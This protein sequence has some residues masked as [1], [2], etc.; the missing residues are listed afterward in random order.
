MADP[1]F[2]RPASPEA[3]QK[4]ETITPTE[5][6]FLKSGDEMNAENRGPESLGE[7][8]ARLA[9]EGMAKIN[10]MGKNLN[11]QAEAGAQEFKQETKSLWGRVKDRMF[12]KKEAAPIKGEAD[13]LKEIEKA[14]AVYAEFKKK[15]E[16]VM[17]TGDEAALRG[18]ESSLSQAYEQLAPKVA[19]EGA[20]ESKQWKQALKTGEMPQ[21]TEA[22]AKL[23]DVTRR[24]MEVRGKLNGAPA[25]NA[26]AAPSAAPAAPDTREQPPVP[27]A[28]PE[29]ANPLKKDF[30]ECGLAGAEAA[31]LE[32]GRAKLESA[33]ATSPAAEQAPAPKPAPAAEKPAAP[34]EAAPENPDQAERAEYEKMAAG[35]PGEK[36]VGEYLR[37][38]KL[39][40][41][42]YG[43]IVGQSFDSRKGEIRLTYEDGSQF[44]KYATGMMLRILPGGKVE[45][46]KA[47]AVPSPEAAAPGKKQEE[48]Q[49]VD[50]DVSDLGETPV[51][52]VVSGEIEAK[53][54]APEP[55]REPSVVVESEAVPKPQ[56]EIVEEPE[57][58][59]ELFTDAEKARLNQD[60]ERLAQMVKDAKERAAEPPEDDANV[61]DM[62]DIGGGNFVSAAE[63]AAREKAP[64][65]ALPPS[66]EAP[67]PAETPA[68]AV[69]PGPDLEVT[70]AP[71]AEAAPEQAPSGEV[72]EVEMAKAKEHPLAPESLPAILKAMSDKGKH[73]D[74][75]FSTPAPFRDALE[76]AGFK[77]PGDMESEE[78]KK[79]HN[80]YKKATRK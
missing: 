39:K 64:M 56:A 11:L 68:Y 23:N 65:K 32:R 69:E 14:D 37:L 73:G 74:G 8:E 13:V 62:V 19:E 80:A 48:D 63:A 21:I 31:A 7:T 25:A 22:G 58:E 3:R 78:L 33:P 55:A 61:I 12:G 1:A 36:M 15:Y 10:E 42:Q 2:Y 49:S 79:L 29:A 28:P 71:K 18:M 27:P 45:E 34:P 30:G 50:I 44:R 5:E 4:A 59:E 67:K 43:R 24:L 54:E 40:A 6:A 51:E 76:A 46:I 66:P 70:P 16:E 60:A 9:R 17:A 20:A 35:T 38:K 41:D 72:G 47:V 52:G 57:A 75:K 77:F 53:P 26:E